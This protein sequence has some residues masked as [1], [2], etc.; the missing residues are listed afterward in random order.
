MS[1]SGGRYADYDND[2]LFQERRDLKRLVFNHQ[3]GDWRDP[4]ER[5][6]RSELLEHNRATLD[7][8]EAEI[9]FRHQEKERRQAERDER[10][11]F[12]D[13]RERRRAE[14]EE[15]AAAT[16]V[17]R[18]E[19]QVSGPAYAI[20]PNPANETVRKYFDR[21]S[22]TEAPIVATARTEMSWDLNGRHYIGI[23]KSGGAGLEVWIQVP[24]GTPD[25][26]NISGLAFLPANTKGQIGQALA[27]E[28]RV[29]R[30]SPQ[31]TEPHWPPCAH[32]PTVKAPDGRCTICTPLR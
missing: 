9:A 27:A 32:P 31:S 16:R 7:A 18:R 19:S 12:R 23:W 2:A 8:I 3:R 17:H 5:R 4:D 14:R 10:N 26:T 29:Q 20:V 24:A 28:K 21:T 6:A 30:A 1:N 13:E 25:A 15:A 11:R 22:L